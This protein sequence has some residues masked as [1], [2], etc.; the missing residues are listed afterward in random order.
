M[1]F[2]LLTSVFSALAVFKL[3]YDKSI[4]VLSAPL[5]PVK[6]PVTSAIFNIFEA[7]FIISVVNFVAL[8]RGF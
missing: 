5:L 7:V 8:S 4:I 3:L 1:V 6:S 2:I